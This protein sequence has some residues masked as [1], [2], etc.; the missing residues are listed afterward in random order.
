VE[1]EGQGAEHQNLD[2][3]LNTERDT[4][5]IAGMAET[6]WEKGSGE[7]DR[8]GDD[9]DNGADREENSRDVEDNSKNA[10]DSRGDS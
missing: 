9:K 10:E 8:D 1:Q 5:R 7:K 4:E 2:K 3:K 6:T